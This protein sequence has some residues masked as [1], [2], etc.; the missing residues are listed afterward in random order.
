M[1]EGGCGY[2]KQQK[3]FLWCWNGSVYDCGSDAQT[4]EC[5]KTVQS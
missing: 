4:Y 2:K 3:N 1:D 5:E